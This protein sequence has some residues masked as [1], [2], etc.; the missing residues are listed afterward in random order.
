MRIKFPRVVVG[1]VRNA[2]ALA[3]RLVASAVV[4]LLTFGV[5]GFAL[6][7]SGVGV[8]YGAGWALIAGGVACL[9]AAAFIK[10]GL[11]NG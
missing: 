11:T 5:L 6:L 10:Q 2:G 4:W 9:A 3:V 8:L 1:V 7:V